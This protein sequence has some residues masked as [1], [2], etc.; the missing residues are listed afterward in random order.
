[1][2][3][4]M[5]REAGN[6][7]ICIVHQLPDI[8]WK[9]VWRNLHYAPAPERYKSKWFEVIHDILPTQDQLHKSRLSPTYKCRNCQE[10]DTIA[11]RIITCGNRREIWHWTKRRVAQI[12]N[13]TPDHILDEWPTLHTMTTTT[14][15]CC[16]FDAGNTANISHSITTGTDPTGIHRHL[17]KVTMET[18]HEGHPEERSGNCITNAGFLPLSRNPAHKCE[19]LSPPPNRQCPIGGA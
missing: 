16:V 5:R 8:Y 4:M 19:V 17:K 1:M 2:H 14:E 18:L 12:L 15:P 13:T 10:P 6:Q 3:T 9:A 7:D 11:H